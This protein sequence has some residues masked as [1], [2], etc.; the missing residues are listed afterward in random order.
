[1]RI[2][3]LSLLLGSTLAAAAC[4]ERTSKETMIMAPERFRFSAAERATLKEGIDVDA[5]ERLAAR[6]PP[7]H[8][9]DFLRFWR[10]DFRG[11]IV[12]S[13]DPESSALLKQVWAPIGGAIPDVPAH[14]RL[15]PYRRPVELVLVREL[16]DPR[17]GALV[18]REAAGG[19]DI[20]V[21]HEANATA[22][23]LSI[24]QGELDRDRQGHGL[25]PGVERRFS[26]ERLPDNDAAR[27]AEPFLQNIYG[28]YLSALHDA[29]LEEI[30]G[31]GRGRRIVMIAPGQGTRH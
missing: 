23:Q 6:V 10:A 12:D 14:Q 16:E 18:I 9:A 22:L 30:R 11:G 29:P 31:V 25:V 13:D 28:S 20:I 26:V 1:M 27:P 7:E 5:L 24:A 17:A 3:S 4:A 21:L 8:R 19:R 2:L 15:P